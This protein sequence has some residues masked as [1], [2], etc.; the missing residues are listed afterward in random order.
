[1][2][3]FITQSLAFIIIAALIGLGAGLWIGWIVWGGRAK[4]RHAAEKTEAARAAEAT[5]AAAAA[6]RT[7][8]DEAESED[9]P[10]AVPAVPAAAEA[11]SGTAESPSDETAADEAEPRATDEADT[12]ET[13]TTGTDT[14]GTDAG[15][16]AEIAAA[17]SDVVA[18]AEAVARAAAEASAEPAPADDLQRIEGVGPKIA[19][20][21]AS[22]GYTTYAAI[23]AASEDELRAAV[24]GQ[25]IRF[26]PSASTWA[27]QAS[28]LVDG[29]TEGLDEYQDYLV[30]GQERRAKFHPGV[31]YTDVDEIDGAAAKAAAL[32]ADEAKAAQAEPEPEPEPQ[33]QDL[34]RIEGIGPKIEAVLQAAG[35]TTYA[36]LAAASEEELRTLLAGGGITFAPAAA[37]WADQAQYLVDGDEAGLEEYQDY[38]VA[39]QER[40]AKFH[41]EVDYTDVDEID[42]AAAK[43]AALAADEAK[44]EAAEAAD[45]PADEPA[46]G[47]AD[48]KQPGVT[49]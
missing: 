35:V 11:T 46:E 42:G 27:D 26:A 30:A 7:D 13:D 10:E 9:A 45:G 31:D 24:A 43:A 2:G 19:A 34:Q 41:P 16:E 21:L 37:T 3:W 25:G 44:V 1:M 29:D 22:A 5:G 6:D 4:G 12:T 38:L 15:T 33:P 39:G 32:A 49:A 48:P 47:D 20:A 23:A 28:Y 14:T 8:D 40:R 17:G 18:E 36:R